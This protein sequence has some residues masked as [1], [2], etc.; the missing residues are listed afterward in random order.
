ML[1]ASEST[2]NR[3]G[4]LSTS[5]AILFLIDVGQSRSDERSPMHRRSKGRSVPVP[6]RIGVQTSRNA[7]NLFLPHLSH[8]FIGRVDLIFASAGL[9]PAACVRP[10]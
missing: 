7:F 9:S 2:P 5:R 4:V 6:G 1:S 10:S 3:G 8:C